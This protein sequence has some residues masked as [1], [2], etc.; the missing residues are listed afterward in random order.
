[1]PLDGA[2]LA[3]QLNAIAEREGALFRAVRAELS[4]LG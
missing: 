4:A 2:L 3:N 1:M